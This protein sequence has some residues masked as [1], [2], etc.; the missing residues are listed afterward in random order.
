[1]IAAEA[2][3]RELVPMLAALLLRSGTSITHFDGFDGVDTH[4][5]MS[6]IG[7]Q[8]VKDGLSEPWRNARRDNSH[9]STNRVA[10]AADLPDQLLQLLNPGRI[11]AEEWVLVGKCRIDRVEFERADL[12]EIAGDSHAQALSQILPRDGTCGH[13]HDCLASR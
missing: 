10:L 8:A 4:Q 11:G 5:R 1:M 7:I 3:R 13:T 2:L 12:A 6:D 9:A